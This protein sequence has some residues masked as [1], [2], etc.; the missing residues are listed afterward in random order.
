M[1]NAASF[2]ADFSRFLRCLMASFVGSYASAMAY[3]FNS[4]GRQVTSFFE[5][6]A[7]SHSCAIFA[8]LL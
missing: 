8:L 1:P 4:A 6:L 3:L 2:A 5:R 7:K